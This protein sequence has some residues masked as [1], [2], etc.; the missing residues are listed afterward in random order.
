MFLRSVVMRYVF[1]IVCAALFV[2]APAHA[3]F[4][5]WFSNDEEPQK[6]VIG[7]A[8]RVHVKEAKMMMKARID[9]GALLSSIHARV[10]KITP[11]EKKGDPEQITFEI[12]NDGETKTLT[13]DLVR[14]V[15]IKRKGVAGFIKRPVVHLNMCIAGRMVNGEVNLANRSRFIYP[16]LIGRNILR[17]AEFVVDSAERY[18]H[19]AVCPN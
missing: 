14:W 12:F 17:Q 10:I 1:F 18:K 5:D 9:T 3:G 8:E 16:L 11:G 2:S 13:S 7:W 4:L 19:K 6:Q 15:Q